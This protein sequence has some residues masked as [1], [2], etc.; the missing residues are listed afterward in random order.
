MV[1]KVGEGAFIGLHDTSSI[2]CIVGDVAILIFP[3]LLTRRKLATPFRYSVSVDTA[4]HRC[5]AIH[6]IGCITTPLSSSSSSSSRRARDPQLR[7]RH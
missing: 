1:I 2:R 5:F 7:A 6:C 3:H 4:I